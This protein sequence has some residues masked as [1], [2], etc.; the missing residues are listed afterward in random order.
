VH[1]VHAV[2]L[3]RIDHH[4]QLLQHILVLRAH[5]GIE[6]CRHQ[7]VLGDPT[8]VTLHR[9]DLLE[10]IREMRAQIFRKLIINLRIE[11]HILF[12][13]IAWQLWQ[14]WHATLPAC[15]ARGSYAGSAYGGN[16]C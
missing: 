3:V 11:M 6:Q 1:L 7:L 12:S 15:S 8:S 9:T 16:D 10:H 4:H 2:G 13:Q 5:T 14:L